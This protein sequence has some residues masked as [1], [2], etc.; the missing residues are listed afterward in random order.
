MKGSGRRV[1]GPAQGFASMLAETLRVPRHSPSKWLDEVQDFLV[2]YHGLEGKKYQLLGC[3][4]QEVA[5]RLIRKAHR[6]LK[7]RRRYRG[8]RNKRPFPSIWISDSFCRH[9]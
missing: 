1:T 6:E 7:C 3:K 2:N 5:F 4:G 8:Q 9:P